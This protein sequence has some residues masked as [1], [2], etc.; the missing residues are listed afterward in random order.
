MPIK[1]KY[2][3]FINGEFVEPASGNYVDSTDPH[4]QSIVSQIARANLDDMERAI[5]AA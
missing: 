3:L 1:S 2:G 4:D 5:K